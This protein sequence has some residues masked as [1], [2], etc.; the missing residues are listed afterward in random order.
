VAASSI[1][2]TAPS[3][4]AQTAD[5]ASPAPDPT[6]AIPVGLATETPGQVIAL[7]PP[8]RD[9]ELGPA[10]YRC[11]TPCTVELPP[12][13]YRVHVEETKDTRA[14][15]RIVSLSGPSFVQV[16]PR[17]HEQR[18]I[19][20]GLGVGGIVL[21]Q[22]G[23]VLLVVGALSEF[24]CTGSRID[25]GC[26]GGGHFVAPGLAMIVAGLVTAPIGWVI[27]GKSF[28]PR[29]DIEPARV[30]NKAEDRRRFFVGGVDRPGSVGLS[31]GVAF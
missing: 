14:G 10:L 7:Y 21:F 3:I 22:A 4:R 28:R 29:V 19:G 16:S 27:F 9:S 23:T 5:V 6:A 20:L 24:A 2:I 11:V 18:W 13:K 26:S 12:G 17:T 31:L 30:K 15:S 25:E 1:A 8:E